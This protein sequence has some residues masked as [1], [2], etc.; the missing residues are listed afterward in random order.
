MR[1]V[2]WLILN[3]LRNLRTS[4]TFRFKEVIVQ[5]LLLGYLHRTYW[6]SFIHFL[7]N[8]MYIM[9]KIPQGREKVCTLVRKGSSD[10]KKE[11]GST[12]LFWTSA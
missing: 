4:R 2:F 8:S 5:V 12:V 9:K 3:F 6:S 11:E 10:W 7:L 1:F